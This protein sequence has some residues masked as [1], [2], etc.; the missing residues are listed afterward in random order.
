MRDTVK[1]EVWLKM[2]I[3]SFVAHVDGDFREVKSFLDLL[4]AFVI[5]FPLAFID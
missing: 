4:C 2:K 5:W 3:I 1:L